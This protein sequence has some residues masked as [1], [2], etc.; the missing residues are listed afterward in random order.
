VFGFVRNKRS[1]NLFD[2]IHINLV[3]RSCFWIVN[4]S[5]GFS[6]LLLTAATSPIRVERLPVGMM[7]MYG[8]GSRP[9]N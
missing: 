7:L 2:G 8:G 9:I 6:A 3:V 1:I 4:G 5:I